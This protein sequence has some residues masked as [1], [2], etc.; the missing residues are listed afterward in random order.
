[1]VLFPCW[2][3]CFSI[4]VCRD[5]RSS[6]LPQRVPALPPPP[7]LPP[8]SRIPL[9]RLPPHPSPSS[10]LFRARVRL[11]P[12]LDQSPLRRPHPQWV[13][14]HPPPPNGTA[15]TAH[16]ALGGDFRL[17]P[18]GISPTLPY[19]LANPPLLPPPAAQATEERR[20]S[21]QQPQE[22]DQQ[23]WL[24]RRARHTPP[25]LVAAASARWLAYERRA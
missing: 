10:P 7:Q 1:M 16:R 8:L 4:T 13:L 12:L 5:C 17:L 24:R 23:Q 14:P 15:A 11:C 19:L 2:A 6:P 25:W 22:G 9:Q 3:G 21:Q 20:G 18:P